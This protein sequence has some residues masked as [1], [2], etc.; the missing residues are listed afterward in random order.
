MNNATENY[1]HLDLAFDEE[2]QQYKIYD[3]KCVFTDGVSYPEPYVFNQS[4]VGELLDLSFEANFS[5]E[6]KTAILLSNAALTRKDAIE[7]MSIDGFNQPSVWTA[8]MN[9]PDLK[10]ELG[11]RVA[12]KRTLNLIARGAD[13]PPNPSTGRA[14]AA[15]QYDGREKARLEA[16]AAR[17]TEEAQ[18]AQE[19]QAR[20][21]RLARFGDPIG[22]YMATPTKL[23]A[24]IAEDGRRNPNKVN[25]FVAPIPTEI[26]LSLTMQGITGLAFYDTFLVD[27]LPRIYEDHGVFLINEIQHGVSP[28]GW[29]TTIGGLYYF[30]NLTGKGQPS[31]GPIASDE[32][33]VSPIDLIGTGP[34][35]S[36]A[37]QDELA[38]Q[39]AVQRA[40]SPTSKFS[41]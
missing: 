28:D 30:V 4:N 10:D 23:I 19:A 24:A 33:F 15:T 7:Q 31:G 3:K 21:T 27:K 5:K 38:K 12:T 39:A 2:T 37:A 29:I 32:E 20:T 8:V 14:F 36:Q 40:T 41:L 1:W 22:P 11:E 18:E 34:F 25:S 35:E 26:N 13:P 16:D 6:S 9:L 17:E